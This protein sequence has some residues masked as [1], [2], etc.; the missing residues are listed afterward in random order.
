MDAQPPEPDPLPSG[1]RFGRYVIQRELAPAGMG[2]VYRAFDTHLSEVVAVNVLSP[3]L[4]NP[5]G[6][7]R[8]RMAFRAGFEKRRG[9]VHDYGEWEGIPFVVMAYDE[10]SGSALDPSRP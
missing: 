5:D 3:S 6:L 9:H 2:R 4:R 1:Y 10:V 7:V 8:F